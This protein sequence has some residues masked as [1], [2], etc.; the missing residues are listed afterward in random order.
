MDVSRRISHAL[1]IAFLWL[2]DLTVVRT[3]AKRVAGPRWSYF[4]IDWSFVLE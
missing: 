1:V 4:F 2:A 3:T